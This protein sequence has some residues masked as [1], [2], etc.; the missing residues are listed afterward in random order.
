M[1][2]VN[3]NYM[4]F[5]IKKQFKFLEL[6]QL[7]VSETNQIFCKLINNAYQADSEQRNHLMNILKNIIMLYYLK[8][9]S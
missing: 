7:N 1:Q 8:L 6:S 5:V 4:I 9:Y 2:H 3:K